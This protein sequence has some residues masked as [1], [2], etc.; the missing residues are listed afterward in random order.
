MAIIVLHANTAW[1]VTAQGGG[2]VTAALTLPSVAKRTS[3][4][5]VL[6]G[7]VGVLALSLLLYA[8]SPNLF[9]ALGA[10]VL[11]G[12]SYMGVLSG[13]N[14]SVQLHAPRAERSRILALYTLSLSMLY[15]LGAFIQADLARVYGVRHVTLASVQV[16][17]LLLLSIR[18]FIPEFWNDMA[19][20]PDQA[21]L[22]LAD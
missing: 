14:T 18:L 12:G 21:P 9:V 3:R 22:L 8:F 20:A 10:L 6:Q 16:L 5:K 13:L 7:S 11:L 4:L 1:L 2:A 15:P 17:V 19:L